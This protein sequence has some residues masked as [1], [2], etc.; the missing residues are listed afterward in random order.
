VIRQQINNVEGLFRMIS[1]EFQVNVDG[2][3]HS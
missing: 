1:E 3:P 2:V